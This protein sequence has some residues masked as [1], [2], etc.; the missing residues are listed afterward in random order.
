MS[1]RQVRLIIGADGEE[2]SRSEAAGAT[3]VIYAWRNP[4]GSSRQATFQNGHLVH[5]AQDRLP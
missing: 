5:K 2:V 4:G 1:Y 3:T